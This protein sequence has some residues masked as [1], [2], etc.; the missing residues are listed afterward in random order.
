MLRAIVLA[1]VLCV[2]CPPALYADQAASL[3]KAL[4]DVN[5]RQGASIALTNLGRPAVPALRDALASTNSDVRV[6]AAYT[7]GEI[8]P[9]AA[10][11]V[12]ELAQAL[13]SSDMALSAAAASALGKT[14]APKAVQSLAQALESKDTAVR[15]NA[16]IALGQ[17]GA[18]AFPAT[19]KLLE[20]LPDRRMTLPARVALVQ[21]GSDKTTEL[22]VEA[23][24]DDTVRFDVA[25]ILRKAHPLIAKRSGV[26]RPTGEDLESLRGV[27][28]D[29]QRSLADSAAATKS[30]AA[31]GEDGFTVLT[32]AFADSRIATLA[33]TAFASAGSEATAT[34]V[35]E[36]KDDRPA[37]RAVA[38]EA[39]ARLG[40]KA[41]GATSDLVRLLKDQDRNVRYQAVRALH[42]LGPAA[43]P[44]LP[45]LGEV[46]LDS[47]EAEPTRQWAIKSLIVTLPKTHD[48][49]VALLIKSSEEKVNYGVRQLARQQ[50]RQID[51]A[52][53][54]SAGVK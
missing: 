20:A 33:A 19:A 50:L 28:F 23:L 7:L 11:A 5:N 32:E 39:M 35:R 2:L 51:P 13:S 44:A 30:L 6:W 43:K 22:L 12:D 10:T 41:A 17:I 42:E 9:D 53:A 24:K 16:I 27:L 4:A 54:D 25:I 14:R 3:I 36:S 46:I 34:L 47:R 38:A 48:Q 40:P 21:I 26:E 37:V 29:P 31:L 49:V 1:G 8:G 45:A 15:R 52:A 18:P